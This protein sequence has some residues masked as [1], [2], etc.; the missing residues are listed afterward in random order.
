MMCT[1]N[2]VDEL[3]II[4]ARKGIIIQQSINVTE[5]TS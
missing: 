4:K 3:E 1:S 5:I 2:L